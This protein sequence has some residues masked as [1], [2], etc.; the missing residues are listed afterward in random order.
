[1]KGVTKRNLL[2]VVGPLVVDS[3]VEWTAAD[4]P[5]RV[6]GTVEIVSGGVLTIQAGV[7]VLFQDISSGIINTGGTLSVLGQSS[8]RV[9]LKPEGE[10]SWLGISFGVQAI[11]ASFTED[12]ESSE[13]SFAEGSVIQYTVIKFA[14]SSSNHALDFRSGSAPFLLGVDL[15]E[16]V[17]PSGYSLAVQQLQGNFV[18]KFLRLA[19][20]STDSTFQPNYAFQIQG[21]GKSNGIV[22]LEDVDVTPVVYDAL[23]VYR[24]SRLVLRDSNLQGSVQ[25]RDIRETSVTGNTITPTRSGTALYAYYLGDGNTPY[26]QTISDNTVSALAGTNS[27]AFYAYYWYKTAENTTITGNTFS[28]GRMEVNYF[29]YGDSFVSITN[30]VVRNSIYGGIILVSF[31]GVNPGDVV[32][33]DNIVEDCE[34]M[35]YSAVQ[36][37]PRSTSFHFRGN[38]ISRCSGRQLVYLDSGSGYESVDFLFEENV[39]EDSAAQDEMAYFYDYPFTSFTK[40]LFDNCTAP[41]SV[42]LEPTRFLSTNDLVYLPANHWGTFQDDIKGSRQTVRDGLTSEVT[43]VID[44]VSVLVTASVD[45]AVEEVDFP[46]LFLPDGSIGGYLTSGDYELVAGDYTCSQTIYLTANATLLVNPGVTI[47]FAPG[48]ALYTAGDSQVSLEGTQDLPIVFQ[49]QVDS[50]WRGVILNSNVAVTMV[51]VV[52]KG[53]KTGINHIGSNALQV[54]STT[55]QDSSSNCIRSYNAISGWKVEDSPVILQDTSLSNCGSYAYF[56]DRRAR[57]TALNCT[58]IGGTYGVYVSNIGNVDITSSTVQETSNYGLYFASGLIHVHDNA[59]WR[60]GGGI[61]LSC[62]NCEG[63]VTGN[64]IEGGLLP[65]NNHAFYG[66][67]R[68]SAGLYIKDNIVAEWDLGDSRYAMYVYFRSSGSDA[69]LDCAGNVFSDITAWNILYLDY[70]SASV[71]TDV[72]NVFDSNLEVTSTS[73][74]ALLVV[75]NWPSGGLPTLKGNVFTAELRN[76]TE[77]FCLQVLESAST[78]PEIDASESFWGSADVLDVTSRI[79]DGRDTVSLSVVTYNP[80]LETLQ[81]PLVNA[82]LPFLRD[83]N[84]LSGT[85]ASGETLSLPKGNYTTDG[86]FVVDGTLIIDAGTIIQMDVASTLS[87]EQGTITAQGTEDEPILFEPLEPGSAWGQIKIG[88]GGTTG[89][90]VLFSHVYVSGAGSSNVAAI[91]IRRAG[92][93]TDL[94]IQDCA[95]GGV[96]VVLNGEAVSFE[97][98]QSTDVSSSTSYNSMQASGTGTVT[99]RNS[100]FSSPAASEILAQNNIRLHVDTVTLE[101]KSIY[102]RGLNVQNE[103]ADVDRLTFSSA[104]VNTT[105]YRPG[106]PVYVYSGSTDEFSMKNSVIDFGYLSRGEAIYLYLWNSLSS[107]NMTDNMFVGAYAERIVNVRS[108][109]SFLMERNVISSSACRYDCFY[110]NSPELRVLSNA[111]RHLVMPESY[112]LIRVISVDPSLTGNTFEDCSGYNLL[113][114]QSAPSNPGFEGNAVLGNISSLEYLVSTTTVFDDLPL[115]FYLLGANFWGTD[116]F[117]VLRTKTRDSVQ[118]ASLA[119]IEFSR[120]YIDETLTTSIAAPPAGSILDETANTIGGTVFEG[121]V[122]QVP[123][124]LYY[125]TSSIIVNH[126]DAEVVFEAGV[127]I[128]FRPSASIT[129]RQGTLKVL[130][131]STATVTFGPT[132]LFAEEYGDPSVVES[133]RWEGIWFGPETNSTALLETEYIDGSLLRHC[134]IVNAGYDG[135]VASVTMESST[136]MMDSVLIEGSGSYGVY[137]NQGSGMDMV[138]KNVA[139]VGS[140]SYGLYTNRLSALLTLNLLNIT[141]SSSTGAYLNYHGDVRVVDSYFK[142]NGGNFYSSYG[143]G[144]LNVTS[145]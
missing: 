97:G 80:F 41:V 113:G 45:S 122:V 135:A 21:N 88:P 92:V 130:G 18:S 23:Y 132:S 98:L 5:V 70:V 39:F 66:S 119:S 19:K 120:I 117:G 78:A 108:A 94:R 99:I 105:G 22:V 129:V 16:C 10:F 9:V 126:P 20:N 144:D 138:G 11:T 72:G 85:L 104:I 59:I 74:P 142:G 49:A 145:R 31:G 25:L 109:Q 84:I 140:N 38:R 123:A 54:V 2:D 115:G 24:V 125:A 86:S 7:E 15:V 95:A 102:T 87:V 67:A 35:S 127:R 42:E 32:I 1:V 6:T 75:G 76:D 89:Q 69:G 110:L 124:G 143:K 44:F 81:G 114:L 3:L 139:I 121:L 8:N 46:G 52:I 79:A 111:F 55:V 12:A 62:N 73:Y 118:D 71:A 43:S 131:T 136:V 40:N 47:T 93:F 68:Y 33:S 34:S 133:D 58:I 13:F 141:G 103:I 83:G 29:I 91:D 112:S 17:G 30:N 101:P 116:D 64:V 27:R 36:L 60:T 28:N 128:M 77:I 61:F 100:F 107:V 63:N 82:T 53:A 65:T 37:I 14:G 137:I 56:V 51:H 134:Q 90:D 57:A 4:N 48:A 26:V 50:D 96:R 106:Y